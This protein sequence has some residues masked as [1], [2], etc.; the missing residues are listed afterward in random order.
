MI[1]I[2]IPTKNEPYI[3][4]LVRRIHKNIKER[5]EI[6]IVDKSDNPL[7]LE[8]AKVLKQTSN[9]LGN[10]VVEGI[11]AS[12]GDIIVIMD[13]DGSHRPE[14]INKLVSKLDRFDI[15]I[16][17]RF[18]INGK[19]KD[20][21]HRKIVSWFFRKMTSWILGLK[22]EDNM[23][24]FSTSKKDVFNKVSL[25][26]RGYKINLELIYK[27][28][29]KGYK[30]GEAPIVFEKRKAGKSKVGINVS[31]IKEVLNILLLIVSLRLGV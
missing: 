26:P 17:S 16:G 29:K 23:S 9:G 19:T 1:S 11:S 5:K 14:D 18:I 25:N 30:V 15:V 22:I 24:G 2:I 13:G 31:G 6:I 20:T 7:F 4:V 21:T 8:D 28:Q 27:A 12:K 3:N 10:A